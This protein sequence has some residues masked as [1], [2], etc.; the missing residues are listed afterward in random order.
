MERISDASTRVFRPKSADRI[1][2][3]GYLVLSVSG[4]D[5]FYVLPRLYVRADAAAATN[6]KAHEGLF[7]AGFAAAL[8]GAASY[9]VVTALLYRLYEPVNRTLSV[10]A[11]L[12]SLTG[13]VIQ[14]VALIFQLIPLLVLADQPYLRAFTLDQRQ[15]L[16]LVLPSSYGQA[17]NRPDRVLGLPQVLKT[18]GGLPGCGPA[19]PRRLTCLL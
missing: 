11:A 13:T 15:A 3:V 14:A 12:F 2:G 4:F 8:I 10:S 19:W 5:L 1:V 7:R 17:F 6:I 18:G 16:A 9:L